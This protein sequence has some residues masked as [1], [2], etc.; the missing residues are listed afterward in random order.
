MI[1]KIRSK[2]RYFLF[3][4]K[5][6]FNCLLGRHDWE[7]NLENEGD[8]FYSSWRVCLFCNKEQYFNPD[9]KKYED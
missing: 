4:L 3:T 7:I 6:R 1:R 5:G 2:I 9:S 8:G